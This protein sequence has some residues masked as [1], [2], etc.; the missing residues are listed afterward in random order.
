MHSL[1][2]WGH[3]P[4]Q[5]A[6]CF[7]VCSGLLAFL[8]GHSAAAERDVLIYDTVET[9]QLDGREWDTVLPR[10]MTVDAVHRSVLLRFPGVADEIKA[11]LDQGLRIERAEIVLDY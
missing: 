7:I 1:S 5:I 4:P 11:R 9:S 2:R 10:A 3:R 8:G 6:A